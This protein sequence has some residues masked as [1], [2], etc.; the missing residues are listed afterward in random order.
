MSPLFFAFL[1]V[2]LVELLLAQ[3]LCNGQETT[4]FRLWN[5]HSINKKEMEIKR[6]RNFARLNERL[7]HH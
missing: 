6:E 7:E 1:W 2:F 5:F 3:S 4:M